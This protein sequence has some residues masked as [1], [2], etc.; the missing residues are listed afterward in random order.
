MTFRRRRNGRRA[1]A[2]TQRLGTL[3]GGYRLSRAW[4][5][6]FT[7]WVPSVAALR[8][9]AEN[10]FDAGPY[11]LSYGKV[12]GTPDWELHPKIGLTLKSGSILNWTT[13]VK[14]PLHC[15]S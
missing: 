12:A 2:S 7:A 11:H 14:V 4:D 15:L 5:G 13:G 8:A 3:G 10:L 6:L 9:L 1:L